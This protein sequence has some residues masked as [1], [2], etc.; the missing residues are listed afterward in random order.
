MRNEITRAT[1]IET[2][3]FWVEYD[4]ETGLFRL[5]LSSPVEV[6]SVTI[7]EFSVNLPESLVRLMAEMLP[8][9][10]PEIVH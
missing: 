10:E 7:S 9:G 1:R 3:Q 4:Q 6:E 5:T 2:D 8:P